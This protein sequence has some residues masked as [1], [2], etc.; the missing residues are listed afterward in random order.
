M[1][2]RPMPAV[3]PAGA[4][5][6]ELT[7]RLPAVDLETVLAR[8][9]LQQRIDTKFVVFPA[10]LDQLTGL[11]IDLAVL[12]IAGRRRFGYSSSYLDTPD[13]RTFRDHVQ[14]RRRR[15]K[16][17]VRTYTDSG[18]RHLELK[19]AGFRGTT[20][21][22]RWQLP[23]GHQAHDAIDAID[24]IDAQALR[25]VEEALAERGLLVPQGLRPSLT[26]AYTRTTLVG[27]DRPVRLTVDTDLRAHGEGRGVEALRDRV[28]LEV[29][30]ASPHEEIVTRL[31]RLGIR[32]A[33]ISKYGIGLGLTRPGLPV[34][35]WAEAIR[36]HFNAAA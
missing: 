14:G 30:S 34:Q 21:K 33:R 9:E 6:D 28:L 5:V 2:A 36:D 26:T 16:V 8:A 27:M 11:G 25:P 18:Q 29:K 3:S 7:H 15:Y 17:R 24:A 23:T 13:L 22:L 4:A 20:D 31:S 12:D 19:L 10:V 35:P 1:S 32:P